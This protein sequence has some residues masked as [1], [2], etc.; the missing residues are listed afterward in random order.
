[1]KKLVWILPVIIMAFA[2]CT[3]DSNKDGDIDQ[4]TFK[5][6]VII[7]GDTIKMEQQGLTGY[8]NGPGSG[9][10]VADTANN[11]LFRQITQFASPTDTLRIYFIEIFP[12]EPT[13][14][15]KEA[16]VKVGSYPTGYGTFDV[17]APDANLKDGAAVVYVDANGTRW[18][19]DRNPE[20]QPNWSFNVT[21]HTDN[22]KDAFSKYITDMNFSV[23][24]HNPLNGDFIDVRALEMCARTVAQ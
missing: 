17:I 11:Y 16:I 12:Q 19:T 23:R 9:G 4:S 2:A 13:A 20:T 3:K 10:G 1:M 8:S 6:T 18:T 24:L 14:A 21:A 7:D 5:A 22:S 15:Q